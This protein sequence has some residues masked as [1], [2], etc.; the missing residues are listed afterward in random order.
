MNLNF[1]LKL[2]GIY[3]KVDTLHQHVDTLIRKWRAFLPKEKQQEFEGDFN[4]IIAEAKSILK[5]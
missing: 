4:S 2:F 3:Q 1:L 5:K